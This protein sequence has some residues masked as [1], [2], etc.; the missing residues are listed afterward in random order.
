MRKL[1]LFVAL[2]LFISFVSFS[3]E[4]L[5]KITHSYFR[6]DPFISDFSTFLKHLLNDPTL[7]DKEFRK[8]TDTSFF[9]FKGVYKNHNPFFF[10]PSKIEVVLTEMK[11]ARDSAGTDTIYIYQ[12][13]AYTNSTDKENNGLKKEFEKIYRRYKGNFS[14]SSYVENP[15]GSTIPNGTYNFFNRLCA[16]APFAITWVGPDSNSEMALILTIRMS[17]RGNRATLPIPLY[18][19]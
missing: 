5:A 19:F 11:I 2:F 8:K 6:S 4:S 3:Q 9:Y 15:G 10:Q 7:A 17:T 1:C 18:A 13:L 16:V 14:S 12:L